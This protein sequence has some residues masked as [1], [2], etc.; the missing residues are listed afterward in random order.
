MIDEKIPLESAFGHTG[1][2]KTTDPTE[3][4]VLVRF[5]RPCP[6]WQ[7][8]EIAGFPETRAMELVKPLSSNLGGPIA[9]LY[10]PSE[11][12]E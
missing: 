4:K 7:T 2:R 9:E 1:S 5:L 6:P 8:G 11:M 3:P 10:V 12:E